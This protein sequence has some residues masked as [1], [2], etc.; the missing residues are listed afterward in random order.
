MPLEGGFISLTRETLLKCEVG[1]MLVDRDGVP[2]SIVKVINDTDGVP[3]SFHLERQHDSHHMTITIVPG[4]KAGL[5]CDWVITDDSNKNLSEN[6][7]SEKFMDKNFSIEG[8]IHTP[9]YFT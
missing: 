5:R 1:Y 4:E 7:P 3:S 6:T 8:K 9:D 2:W